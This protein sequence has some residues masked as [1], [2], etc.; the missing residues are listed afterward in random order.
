MLDYIPLTVS[1]GRKLLAS[2]RF[3]LLVAVAL[4]LASC[5]RQPAAQALPL[6]QTSPL[7][8]AA[9]VRSPVWSAS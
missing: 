1:A 3:A 7:A 9:A 5:G 4:T 2:A 6:Q 8:S